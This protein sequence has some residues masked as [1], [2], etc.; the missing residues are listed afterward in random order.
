MTC[1]ATGTSY[2]DCD[3]KSVS[4]TSADVSVCTLQMRT[5]GVMHI[6]RV[7]PLRHK[8]HRIR[9]TGRI[10]ADVGTAKAHFAGP[11]TLLNGI[12][13]T[14]TKNLSTVPIDFDSAEIRF[15]KLGKQDIET[16]IEEQSRWSAAFNQIDQNDLT[17]TV[18]L[19]P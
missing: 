4:G 7:T 10:N 8:Y 13:W 15:A 14:E 16:V 5:T 18:D 9:V 6:V 1:E 17:I 19:T 12:E 11:T 3:F 2:Y